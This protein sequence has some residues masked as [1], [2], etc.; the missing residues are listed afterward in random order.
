M[1]NAADCHPH[2][3]GYAIFVNGVKVWP[4]GDNQW[5]NMRQ[6]SRNVDYTAQLNAAMPRSI[7]VAEGDCIEFL[8]RGD[9]GKSGTWD[10][11]GNVFLPKVTYDSE[12]MVSAVLNDKFAITLYPAG[13]L[14][15]GQ[16]A[17]LNG[18]SVT[19]TLD[20]DGGYTIAGIAAKEMCDTIVWQYAYAATDFAR[21]DRTVTVPH[22]AQQWQGSYADLMKAYIDAYAED[23][24]DLGVAI[25]SLAVAT[26]NYGAAA[27]TYFGYK[28]DSLVNAILS[29][30][31]KTVTHGT[32]YETA[33]M[34]QLEGMPTAELKGATLLLN[35]RINIK[36]LVSTSV[37]GARL[38]IAN[39][40]GFTNA[41]TI[42]FAAENETTLKAIMD[43]L[44]PAI[45]NTSFYFRVV[46]A[47]GNAIS[48]TLRYSVAA[49]CQNMI[50]KQDAQVAPVADAILALY[51]AVAAYMA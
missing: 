44:S 39:N 47:D 46:D 3:V 25:T 31:Q 45:W 20:S 36:L 38:Q 35:D 21:G 42:D 29:D 43:G 19:P 28:T 1:R 7:F 5:Y 9:N 24:S 32:G 51:D 10:N 40:D 30:E 34:T 4:Y 27:Q 16:T 17:T 49:Y 41:S 33:A 18:E 48:H 2:T 23:T 6:E 22:V 37:E 15:D 13:E 8:A 14:A 12:T 50:N 11:R 26:L